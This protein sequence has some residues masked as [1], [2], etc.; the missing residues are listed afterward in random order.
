MHLPL[1]TS[2]EIARQEA[3]LLLQAVHEIRYLLYHA[4]VCTE[5][6]LL[7]KNDAEIEDELIAVVSRRLHANWIA[8]YTVSIC[9]DL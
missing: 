8:Q 4:L 2:G 7:S 3:I 6:V 1:A 5:V 9:A